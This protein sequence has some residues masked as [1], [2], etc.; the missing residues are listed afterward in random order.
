MKPTRY[1]HSSK[2]QL[3]AMALALMAGSGAWAANPPPPPP[4]PTTTTTYIDQYLFT[5]LDPGLYNATINY[6]WSDV[7]LTRKNN[8]NQE[9]NANSLGWALTNSSLSGSFTDVSDLPSDSGTIHLNG[10][11]AGTYTLTLTGNWN[12]VETPESWKQTAASVALLDGDFIGKIQGKDVYEANSFKATLVSAVPEPASY[13]ML[14]AGL[15]LIGTIAVR[16]R[17]KEHA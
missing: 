11:S 10:L 7:L 12:V 2:F 17:P 13:A 6:T 1:S 8:S 9:F 15:G 16:R 5:L 3:C 14:L 4:P